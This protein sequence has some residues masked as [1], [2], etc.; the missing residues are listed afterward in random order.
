MTPTEALRKH[1]MRDKETIFAVS[2]DLGDAFGGHGGL[3]VEDATKVILIGE[4]VVLAGEE[5]ATR[6]HCSKIQ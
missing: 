2:A 4:H 5:R 6:V 1:N 3:V